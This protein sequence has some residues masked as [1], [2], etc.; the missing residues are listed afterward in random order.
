VST[1]DFKHILVATDFGEPA[2]RALDV[3][4]ALAEKL[5]Q[6]A[7]TLVHVLYIARPLY[8]IEVAW[9]TEAMAKGAQKAL[10]VVLARARKRY[11]KCQGDLLA[12]AP[13]EQIVKA[14]TQR[15]AD[16]VVIGTHG[17]RG[18]P[19]MLLGSVA[20]RVTRTC[21]VPVLTVPAEDSVAAERKRELARA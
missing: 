4:I 19:R 7:L 13:A 11:P 17:R 2:A 21:P 12:G 3:A 14:V 6:P 9:P 15:G 16:L 5:G 20:E 18:L 8:D 10:D 1:V